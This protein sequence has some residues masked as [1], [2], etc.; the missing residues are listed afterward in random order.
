MIL[1]LQGYITDLGIYM[2]N[3]KLVVMELWNPQYVILRSVECITNNIAPTLCAM[4]SHA[5]LL[6]YD[7]L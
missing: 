7:V 2:K 3:K 4:F 5:I 1:I 6:K